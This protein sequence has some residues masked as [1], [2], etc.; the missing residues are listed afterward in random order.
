METDF[1]NDKKFCPHCEDYVSYLQS[2]EQSYCIECGQQVRLFSDEDWDQFHASL[3]DRK[4]KGG[5]PR[6]TQRGKESA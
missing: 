3:Q 2:M 1:Y 4:P 6:K 5:R